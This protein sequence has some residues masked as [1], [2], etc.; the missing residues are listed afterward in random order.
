MALECWTWVMNNDKSLEKE[1]EF[2]RLK[3]FSFDFQLSSCGACCLLLNPFPLQRESII[4]HVLNSI[5]FKI[6]QK[7]ENTK[8]WKFFTLNWIRVE[9]SPLI[10]VMWPLGNGSYFSYECKTRNSNKQQRQQ[11]STKPSLLHPAAVATHEKFPT[12]VWS[13]ETI[14]LSFSRCNWAQFTRLYSI[15]QQAK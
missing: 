13:A 5:I 2:R 9:E 14:E 15:I 7:K 12:R 1:V 6:I 8:N 10:R 11:N 3:F 4:S